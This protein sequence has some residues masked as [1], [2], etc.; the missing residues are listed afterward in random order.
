NTVQSADESMMELE[1]AMRTINQHL[2]TIMYDVEG[3]ARN[4]N[5]FARGLRENPAR[6]LRQAPPAEPGSP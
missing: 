5:E 3:G 2:G 6:L 4:M 1:Q